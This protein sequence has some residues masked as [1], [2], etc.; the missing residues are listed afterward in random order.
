M[1]K[2]L[3]I[4]MPQYPLATNLSGDADGDRQRALAARRR[5]EGSMILEA[6]ERRAPTASISWLSS[7]KESELGKWCLRAGDVA[8]VPA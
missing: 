7:G 5:I 2:P 1:S 8:G 4:V 3:F 6:G